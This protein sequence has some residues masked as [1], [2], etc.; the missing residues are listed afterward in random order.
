MGVVEHREAL[1]PD[2]RHLVIRHDELV[3]RLDDRRRLG[4]DEDLLPL[5]DQAPVLRVAEPPEGRELRQCHL[6]L[7]H[8]A[9]CTDD[10]RQR[11]SGCS[12]K[13]PVRSR[14]RFMKTAVVGESAA[15]EPRGE[16]LAD[17]VDVLVHLLL[18]DV[19]DRRDLDDQLVERAV[20]RCRLLIRPWRVEAREDRIAEALDARSPELKYTGS[21]DPGTPKKQFSL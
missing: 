8:V 21:L 1:P 3:D 5:L 12:S 10:M 4:V 2:E 17:G 18:H 13:R 7:L 19:R 6:Q 16:R 14:Q 9:T 15:L 20:V 11:G